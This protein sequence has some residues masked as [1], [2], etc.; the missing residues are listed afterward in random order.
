MYAKKSCGQTKKSSGDRFISFLNRK[1]QAQYLDDY[2]NHSA[3]RRNIFGHI[4]C[5][6][7]HIGQRHALRQLL[8]G[9]LL[10]LLLFHL[11]AVV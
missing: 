8:H 7:E 4:F 3:G 10:T 1:K 5:D 9:H 2:F 6:V 11:V